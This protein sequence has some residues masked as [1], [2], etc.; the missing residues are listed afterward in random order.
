MR[1]KERNLHQTIK[2]LRTPRTIQTNKE[3]KQTKL[4]RLVASI[5]LRNQRPICL[6]GLT[7]SNHNLSC[8][9]CKAIWVHYEN[10]VKYDLSRLENNDTGFKIDHLRAIQGT[11]LVQNSR[12]VLNLK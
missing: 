7:V 5:S 9:Y 1:E 11:R 3:N 12:S 10:S 8:A 6:T 4:F 2:I